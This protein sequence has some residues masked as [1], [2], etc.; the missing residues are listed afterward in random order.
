MGLFDRFLNKG[1]K[2]TSQAPQSHQ[3]KSPATRGEPYEVTHEYTPEGYLKVELYEN[4]PKKGRFYDVT[5]LII[6]GPVYMPTSQITVLNCL[7]SHYGSEDVVLFGS[8]SGRRDDYSHILAEFN[9][10]LL[11]TDK[12]YA[13]SVLVGLMNEARVERYLKD[14]ME[15]SPKHPCGIYIGGINPS[16]RV[17]Y[18]NPAV[19]MESHDSPEMKDKRKKAREKDSER[20]QTELKYYKD[21]IARLQ[22]RIQELE[23]G[24]SDGR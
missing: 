23:G 21:E 11:L 3:P 4:Y 5:R 24:E 6:K 15:E 17:K 20:R 16:T 14:G 19:G 12:T 7:V 22:E 9:T 8:Y 10:D 2:Q 1:K 18:F 13:Y